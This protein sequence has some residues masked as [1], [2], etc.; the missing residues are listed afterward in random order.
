[1]AG[2]KF[3]ERNVGTGRV[4]EVAANDVSAGAGD[5]G[6]VVALN[7]S[8]EIDASMLPAGVSNALSV[9]ASEAI[10]ANAIVEIH[11]VLGVANIRN[12]SADA[13]LGQPG[14]GW[15]AA[16]VAALAS[17]TVFFDGQVGGQVGL[18]AGSR[19]YLASSSPA[20]GT[21]TTTPLSTTGEFHQYLG[22]A[23]SATSFQFE[24]DDPILLA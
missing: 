19:I 17:G 12:A 4:S 14:V 22:K 15:V 11:D 8:G 10:A 23:V 24:P 9:V 20:D 3:L 5:A 6:K 16:A 18:V 13:I 21:I 7:A 2:D 1:M